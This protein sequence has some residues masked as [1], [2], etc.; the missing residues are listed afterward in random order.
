MRNT[1]SV[2]LLCVLVGCRVSTVLPKIQ[3]LIAPEAVV[4]RVVGD[5]G[6]TE[7]P[8]WLAKEKKLVFSDIPS[9][10]LRSNAD[11][12]K[13][14]SAERSGSSSRRSKGVLGRLSTFT[15]VP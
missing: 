14:H 9:A 7:G 12:G 1:L 15:C 3:D 5:M 10:K 11:K 2:A 6:F 4:V 8:V 13:M